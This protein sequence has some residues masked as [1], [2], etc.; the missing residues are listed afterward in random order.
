MKIYISIPISGHD[1]AAQRAKAREIADKLRKLGHEPVNPFDT[2]KPSGNLSEKEEYAYYIGEDIKKLITCDAVFMCDGW[3]CSK[4]CCI[5]KQ[6]AYILKLTVYEDIDMI[7]S[8][9]TSCR[10]DKAMAFYS[11]L[12]DL[13]EQE[14]ISK[15][16][17]KWCEL[18]RLYVDL[19]GED[20]FV[21]HFNK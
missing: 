7:P 16:Y 18:E 5:E 19:F 1:L 13:V 12:L 8:E 9:I 15:N 3:N 11:H 2:P 6:V 17:P 14:R 21:E 10:T 4:G 20:I